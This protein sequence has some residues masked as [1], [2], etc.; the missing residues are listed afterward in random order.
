MRQN[1][2]PKHRH[3][4]RD[5]RNG[6]DTEMTIGGSSRLVG[7]IFK[8]PGQIDRIIRLFVS[9]LFFRRDYNL[10]TPTKHI[11]GQCQIKMFLSV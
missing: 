11:R 1:D 4:W 9:Q 7:A 3:T 2:A 10:A 5:I 6:I 8:Y